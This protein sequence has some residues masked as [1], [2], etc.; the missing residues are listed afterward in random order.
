[1][2]YGYESGL[3]LL[4]RFNMRTIFSKY[5]CK[6]LFVAVIIAGISGCRPDIKSSEPDPYLKDKAQKYTDFLI[7]WHSTGLGGVSDIVFT[8]SARTQILRTSGSGDSTDWT[9]MYLVTQSVRYILTK[10]PQ[11]RQEVLRIAYYLHVVKDITGD[12]G[13][14]ARYAA[15][16]MAPWNV[17]YPNPDN[18]YAG[19]GK[20]EGYFWLGKNVRDKY[21]SWFWGLAWAFDAVEDEDMRSVIKQDFRDVILTLEKNN[22]KIIDPFGKIYSAADIMPDIRLSILVQA[23]H[24]ID[25]PYFWELLDKEYN[26]VCAVM[27]FASIAFFNRYMEYYAFINNYCVVEPLFRLWP[28]TLRFKYLFGVW[29]MNVR[30]WSSDT[31]N[32]FFDSVYYGIC[33]R[34]GTCSAKELN[35]ISADV[36]HT[37]TVMNDAPNYRRKVTCRDDLPLDQFSVWASSIIE[38]NKW[39]EELTGY[40]LGIEPQTSIAHETDDRCWEPMLWERSPYHTK[41]EGEEDQTYTGPGVDYLIG[42]WLGVYYGVLP[43][44]NRT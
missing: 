43:G 20:Y 13:Y 22:W 7:R 32:A 31:H 40:S 16:D 14:I 29:K 11:A 36:Y 30:M 42:Y 1:M 26:R 18:K 9:A 38:K 6:F 19:E 10:E 25:E 35:S 12:P 41:C 24:V 2:L 23:A 21:I 27:P 4:R 33:Q 15:P 3:F 17:E 37:L 8:D 28:D 5:F 39:F 44:G 34:D